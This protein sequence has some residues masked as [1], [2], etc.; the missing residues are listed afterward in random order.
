LIEGSSCARICAQICPRAP[1]R[2]HKRPLSR[3]VL[4]LG[5]RKLQTTGESNKFCQPEVKVEFQGMRVGFG[6]IQR[7]GLAGLSSSGQRAGLSAHAR[8][9]S[10]ITVCVCVSSK[11]GSP[12]RI[13][14]LLRA[15]RAAWLLRPPTSGGGR[16][17]PIG[18][19]SL[20]KAARPAQNGER[21]ARL[22]PRPRR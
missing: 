20:A 17:Q 12:P 19:L 14:G 13:W 1:L 6:V 2:R 11:R 3:S 16:L 9:H 7:F 22:P 18:P 15:L 5:R 21:A 8:P 4:P 10:G